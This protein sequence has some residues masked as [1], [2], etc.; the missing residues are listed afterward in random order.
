MLP[1][2]IS[3]L[4]Q[5][6]LG[7]GPAGAQ[8]FHAELLRRGIAPTPNPARFEH[9][10]YAPNPVLV[11]GAVIQ[12]MTA[13]AN[14]FCAALRADLGPP[15]ALLARV[16][17]HLRDHYASEE[18]AAQLTASLLQ[19]HPLIC[20]DAFLVETE[21]G[22][23]PAYLEWQTVGT[24]V[25]MGQLAVE[26]A[27]AA[28]PELAEHSPLTATAGL[29]P[30]ALAARLRELYA[31]GIEDD[32]R[33][34]VV[35]DYRPHQCPTRREF[36]AIQD[37]TG[38]PGAGMGVIDPRELLLDGDRFAYRRDGRIIPIR[39]AYSRLVYSDLLALER[40]TDAGRL[41]LIRRF[42][43]EGERI[44][45]ISHPIHFFYGSKADFPAFWQAGLSP[46]IPETRMVTAEF[47]A[48]EAR[49]LAGGGR[50]RGF[51]QKPCDA[52]SGRDVVL[53]PALDELR[54]GCL[55]QREIRP[56]ACHL[57]LHG[58]RTPEV[59]IMAVPD[60]GG[61]LIAGLIYNR[62]KLPEEFLSNAGRLA[63][64]NEAGTGEGYGIVIY[65][66]NV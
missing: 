55:L 16:P 10:L 40:E 61:E 29:A 46:R 48:G 17:A 37:L 35:I 24:Y 63:Q 2:L 1:P 41:A 58:P 39:R 26:A 47:I 60:A 32:P 53:D 64:R 51:V 66:P 54:P 3:E 6:V 31:A 34:G 65:G 25:T 50:L 36:Q 9:N 22:L 62:I 33:Q 15:A 52:Q 28:W 21:R 14:H 4:Y 7:R 13:D 43:Q 57:T 8:R 19:A 18:L 23:E 20:L 38:G 59:R 56:A 30:A 49:E 45:W 5:R 44:S 11:D 27:A 12:A 42:F